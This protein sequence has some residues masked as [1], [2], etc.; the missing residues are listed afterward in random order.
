[1][2]R[3]FVDLISSSKKG[4]RESIEKV[5]DVLKLPNG[6]WEGYSGDFSD[7][8][9]RKNGILYFS[10]YNG[11]HSKCVCFSISK[12]WD[13]SIG[14]SE[15]RSRFKVELVGYNNSFK[16]RPYY[17]GS[18]DEFQS[19]FSFLNFSLLKKRNYIQRCLISNLMLTLLS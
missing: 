13:V 8:Y 3:Y 9:V 2:N 4:R 6:Q 1:M 11:V 17:Y 16:M 5:F 10:I 19:N 12:D 7:P 18:L 14:F 15:S